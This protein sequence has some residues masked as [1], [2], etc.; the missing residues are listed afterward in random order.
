MVQPNPQS[1]LSKVPPGQGGTPAYNVGLIALHFI[2]DNREGLL[3]DQRGDLL[4][5]SPVTGQLSNRAIPC[6]LGDLL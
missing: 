3:T 4:V 6:P 1:L 2:C 5:R